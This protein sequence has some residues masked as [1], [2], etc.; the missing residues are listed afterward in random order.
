MPRTSG[1]GAGDAPGVGRL[2]EAAAP[3]G[4][5]GAEEDE[6]ATGNMDRGWWKRRRGKVPGSGDELV[7]EL[8]LGGV[9]HVERREVG[10][11][12]LSWSCGG[13]VIF[14]RSSI[15]GGHGLIPR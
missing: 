7:G 9:W 11:D 15:D 1:R 2:S 4:R 3:P 14:P 13:E 5:V 8:V 12:E 10:G 6:P